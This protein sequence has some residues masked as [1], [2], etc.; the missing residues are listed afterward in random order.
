MSPKVTWIEISKRKF[1]WAVPTLL[2]AVLTGVSAQQAPVPANGG[3]GMPPGATGL[4]DVTSDP[5]GTLH[6]GPRTVPPN[7]AA[8]PESRAAFI[9]RIKDRLAEAKKPLVT[10]P[11]ALHD[12]GVARR[13]LVARRAM[14]LYPDV[15][16]TETAI[17]GV[18][19]V[20]WKPL[21]IA[22]RN[23]HRVALEFE[24]DPEGVQMAGIG[25]L[26]VISV[27]YGNG[28]PNAA[29]VKDIVKVYREVLK[30]HQAKQ[31]AMFGISGGC[32]QAANT[33]IYLH[34][35]RLPMPGALGLST[36]A[37]GEGDSRVLMNGVDPALS[38]WPDAHR[39]PAPAQSARPSTP[40]PPTPGIPNRI[41]DAVIPPGFPPSYLISGT[42]DMGLSGTVRLQRKLRH[43]GVV[44]D[45][46]V[47]DGVWH[48]F[49][50]LPEL[51]ES[52]DALTDEWHFFDKHLAI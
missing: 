51:P 6:F 33:T 7:M 17:A 31:I 4:A 3:R 14:Q 30:T 35:L 44:V 48:G 5:D 38:I 32:Q 46:N 37:G 45:L 36:C 22:P 24:I 29:G 2:V 42:R 16:R 40:E 11:V 8:S 10:D 43:A 41:W 9:D 39:A 34:Y 47:F 27:H 19:V 23:R 50:Q 12:L 52:K 28:S 15:Q 49:E 25:K 26:E 1:R 13:E 20:V 21:H 18:P